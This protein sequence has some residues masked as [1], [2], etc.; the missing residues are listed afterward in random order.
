MATIKLHP[1]VSDYHRR[2][3]VL[4]SGNNERLEM[5]RDY[6]SGKIVLLDNCGF[7]FDFDLF[8]RIRI[9]EH[10]DRLV[11]YLV[12]KLSMVDYLDVLCDGDDA[13]LVTTE[14]V[15][16]RR[17]A[18]DPAR[19]AA[20]QTLKNYLRQTTFSS[21][22]LRQRLT[23]Q[24]LSFERAVLKFYA[25]VFPEYPYSKYSINWRLTE[26]RGESLHVD[27]Y[28]T[29][30]DF[31]QVK[32]FINLDSAPRIWNTGEQMQTLI[33]RHYVSR[34]LYR[35][36]GEDYQRFLEE[37]D[38]VLFDAKEGPKDC[39]ETH[40]TFFDRGDVW[41]AETRNI[42]HQI[43]FGRKMVSV[44]FYIPASKRIAPE[45]SMQH[46]VA[47]LKPHAGGVLLAKSG[48][49]MRRRVLSMWRGLRSRK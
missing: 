19:E 28:R 17:A 48:A 11:H 12:A 22:E 31:H 44:Q 1:S 32:L 4:G 27:A 47:S 42:P 23:H 8:D 37:C 40:T 18:S 9:D 49:A 33:R 20:Y 15:V 6:E 30:K 26:A 45:V 21:R 5:L 34:G 16:R 2:Y 7:D 25:K 24:I 14:A 35:H 46:F 38:K 43:F 39:H 13:F 3:D 36:H 10:P 41:I 29:E